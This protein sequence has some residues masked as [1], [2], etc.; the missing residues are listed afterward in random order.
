[1][2]YENYIKRDDARVQRVFDALNTFPERSR[3]KAGD[4]ARKFKIPATDVYTAFYYARQ[5]D[6]LRPTGI[7][8]LYVK[9]GTLPIPAV[10]FHQMSATEV[11]D[12]KKNEPEKKASI[13]SQIETLTGMVMALKSQFSKEMESTLH[14][15]LDTKS[16]K[17]TD[18]LTRLEKIEKIIGV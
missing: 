8:G 11:T 9:T 5:C 17:M 14:C 7:R 4:V 12:M 15:M 6:A 18:I 16:N 3:L 10:P 2:A 13:V 1:M